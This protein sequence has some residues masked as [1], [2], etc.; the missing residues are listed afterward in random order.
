MLEMRELKGADTFKMIKIMNKTGVAKA[1]KGLMSGDLGKEIK[2]TMSGEGEDAKDA[3]FEALGVMMA[4]N[5]A[6]IVM[7]EI[8]KAEKDIN[9]FL[10]E[11]TGVSQKQIEE[12]PMVEYTA[13]LVNFFKK[14]EL[15]DFL[16]HIRPLIK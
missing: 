9:K 14:E 11:L 3:K 2:A 1:L 6:E 5:I 15:K 4:V 10:A 12:L 8:D 7:G 13:L 16:S